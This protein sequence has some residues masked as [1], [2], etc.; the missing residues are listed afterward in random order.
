M[1]IHRFYGNYYLII[2]IIIICSKFEFYK[3]M[4]KYL[5][6]IYYFIYLLRN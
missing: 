5:D 4:F 1:K 3:N 2:F 6:I